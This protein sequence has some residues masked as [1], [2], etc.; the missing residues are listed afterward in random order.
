M[1]ANT[2]SIQSFIEREENWEDVEFPV[3]GLIPHDKLSVTT[4]EPF[5]DFSEE[6]Y[7]E[8]EDS[9]GSDCSTLIAKFSPQAVQINGNMMFDP[10]KKQWS[11]IKRSH[12]EE[13]DC[14]DDDDDDWLVD[15]NNSNNKEEEDQFKVGREFDITP[16][17]EAML[18]AAER[19]HGKDMMKWYPA[20]RF[21][22]N[23]E[24]FGLKNMT[25]L[26]GHLY[27]IRKSG[28]I[29]SDV[30]SSLRIYHLRQASTLPAVANTRN[31]PQWT[32]K[33]TATVASLI[34]QYF[35][36]AYSFNTYKIVK[37]LEEKG[38][39]RGQSVAIM[40]CFRALLL[41]TSTTLKSQ[42]LAK[43]GLDNE[44]YLFRAALSELRTEM[45]I[46]RKND[47]AALLSQTS[48]IQR[49]LSAISRRMTDDISTL[50]NE[51]QIDFNNR[52]D[53]IRL[54]QKKMQLKLEEMNNR[55]MIALGEIRTAVEALKWETTRKGII[56]ILG[57]GAFGLL[58][59]FVMEKSARKQ[60]ANQKSTFPEQQDEMTLG[61]IAPVQ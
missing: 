16:G 57:I 12:D 24:R 19:Q 25:V 51:M 26:K 13:S 4:R 21:P 33:Q 47:T 27:E 11:R 38:F 59:M 61:Y 40:K 45:Q 34:R 23:E 60:Q 48:Q 8:E 43:S 7:D 10:V 39:T 44:L 46:L 6:E 9:F 14:S 31:P 53:D 56:A 49:D 52:K 37:E 54:D 58:V 36:T 22:K 1:L 3:S 2:H 42:M 29:H 41:D 15:D 30:K 55:C 17:L 50:K 5:P 32:P 28:F 35:V 20:P 18:F